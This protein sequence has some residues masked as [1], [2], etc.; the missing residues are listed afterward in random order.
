[1]LGEILKDVEIQ[2]QMLGDE[3]H[4]CSVQQLSFR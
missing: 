1:M 3:K 2:G 4:Y